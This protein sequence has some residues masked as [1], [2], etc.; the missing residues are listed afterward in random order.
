MSGQQQPGLKSNNNLAT[1]ATTIGL[2]NQTSQ[3]V[4]LN[5]VSGIGLKSTGK[6]KSAMRPS[7]QSVNA[8]Q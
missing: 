3:A 6:A 2:D 4:G 5:K 7:M 1:S 8:N